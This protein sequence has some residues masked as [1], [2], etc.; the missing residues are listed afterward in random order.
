MA[1]SVVL[2][3][4]F[5]GQSRESGSKMLTEL[6]I[7]HAKSQ[8]GYVRS[9]WLNREDVDGIGVVTF[10]TEDNAKAA[11]KVLGPPPGGPTLKSVD[12]FEVWAEA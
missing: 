4:T 2:Q 7:P 8:P 6:V 5:D 1:F 11:S 10:D 9:E 3:V 12:V